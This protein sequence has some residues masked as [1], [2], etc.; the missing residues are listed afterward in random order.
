MF[1]A[2]SSS[3]ANRGSSASSGLE[4]AGTG[5]H[6]H[7]RSVAFL[8]LG[9]QDLNRARTRLREALWCAGHLYPPEVF[10][11]ASIA[12]ASPAY[13]SAAREWR[14]EFPE[15]AARV[16]IPVRYSLGDHEEV[17]SPGPRRRPTSPPSSRHPLARAL[18]NKPTAGTI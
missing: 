8:E 17:W 6:H 11:E 10:G 4:I 3:V 16:R 15:L 14:Y 7:P 2:I 12:A 9:E 1:S 5:R 18:T 13:E